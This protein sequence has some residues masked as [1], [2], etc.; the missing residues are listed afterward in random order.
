MS[1]TFLPA[2]N[3]LL[4]DLSIGTCLELGI[5]VYSRAMTKHSF[6]LI[7]L[8]GVSFF[9]LKGC[10]WKSPGTAVPKPVV[11]ASETPP[12]LQ[13]K[14][15]HLESKEKGKKY[16]DLEAKKITYN[17]DIG[18]A[19]LTGVSCVFWDKAQQPSVKV[20]AP[21]GEAD[22]NKQILQFYDKVKAVSPKGYT[23]EG[24]TMWWDGGKKR[25][26]GKGGIVISKN[27]S[28]LSGE[29]LEFDPQGK[30]IEVKGNVKVLWLN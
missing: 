11:S 23:L 6:S 16:W 26:Y 17:E 13:F 5:I 8:C 18:K 19:E 25:L 3:K 1:L 15:T 4:R 27:K 22:L 29:E 2:L 20:S 14:T 9:I 30:E 7:L 10:A 24:D 12:T 21:R 28:R